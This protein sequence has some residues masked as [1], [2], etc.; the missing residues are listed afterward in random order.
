M[1]D[2]KYLP[3]MIEFINFLLVWYIIRKNK[4]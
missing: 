3:T 4:D 1:L 2:N